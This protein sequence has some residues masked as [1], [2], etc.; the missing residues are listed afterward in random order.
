M[1]I[2]P[3][4][5][6][7]DSSPR[8]ALGGLGIALLALGY[9]GMALIPSKGLR[10]GLGCAAVVGGVGLLAAS[11]NRT[12]SGRFNLA[13]EELQHRAIVPV[14]PQSA[15]AHI[16]GAVQGSR[17]EHSPG[18]QERIRHQIEVRCALLCELAALPEEERAVAIATLTQ[19]MAEYCDSFSSRKEWVQSEIAVMTAVL[20]DEAWQADPLFRVQI[21]HTACVFCLI[22]V[23][24]KNL[25]VNGYAVQLALWAQQ[26]LTPR[27]LPMIIRE[28]RSYLATDPMPE[29]LEARLQRLLRAWVEQL[30]P[31]QARQI[32]EGQI[33][34]NPT[35]PSAVVAPVSQST[36]GP[37]ELSSTACE[38][39]ATSTPQLTPE[40][41]LPSGAEAQSALAELEAQDRLPVAEGTDE[42]VV[43]SY[44]TRSLLEKA[45]VW[46]RLYPDTPPETIESAIR[47][48]AQDYVDLQ[49]PDNGTYYSEEQRQIRARCA[50]LWDAARL[51]IELRVPV[52]SGIV[53]RIWMRM[54]ESWILSSRESYMRSLPCPNRSLL[55]RMANLE[56]FQ[57]ELS[58]YWRKKCWQS[59][60][61]LCDW[62]SQETTIFQLVGAIEHPELVE[63]DFHMILETITRG[64]S[65]QWH[66]ETIALAQQRLAALPIPEE[67][68]NRKLRHYLS[69]LA[70]LPCSAQVRSA[71]REFIPDEVIQAQA[72]SL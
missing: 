6:R 10:W 47:Q 20:N 67:I 38:A 19:M 30:P 58:R 60:R 17:G 29:V 28:A 26:G 35:A 53:P 66:R 45:Q 9:V 31:G 42:G 36:M 61:A 56:A 16:E 63:N 57:G 71:I 33:L 70:S 3:T 24:H 32:L 5:P 11:C 64:H 21:N 72:G 48:L 59:S 62:L 37:S 8:S 27:L 40:V 13:E 1:R 52:Q 2:T 44:E 22:H 51:P 25:E 43:T 23:V 18:G 54:R 7:S 34:P 46:C 15:A 55:E 12:A 68:R 14:E 65:A 39:V 49:S 50:L 4:R 41:P 69:G